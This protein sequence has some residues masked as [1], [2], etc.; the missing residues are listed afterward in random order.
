MYCILIAGAPA[1]GKS[2]FARFLGSRLSLP[3]IAKDAIK[4]KLFDTVGFRS[5]EEKRKLDICATEV[6]YLLAEADLKAGKSVILDNNFENSSVPSLEALLERTGAIPLTVRFEGDMEIIYNRFVRRDQSPKRH[7]G[8]VVNTCYPET[9][10]EEYV[11]MG[12]EVFKQRYTERGM[13]TFSMGRLIT[14]DCTTGKRID[15]TPIYNK[16]R[17]ITHY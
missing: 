13:T 10:R 6:M 11:P 7:R 5:R 16:I 2:T 3:V 12:A 9:T 8:H 4:E 17:K 15:Y 1:S 14:V